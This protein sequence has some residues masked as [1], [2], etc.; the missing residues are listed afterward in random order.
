MQGDVLLHGH[1]HAVV[2]IDTIGVK[3]EVFGVDWGDLNRNTLFFTGTVGIFSRIDRNCHRNV[4][5]DLLDGH[6]TDASTVN[7]SQKCDLVDAF[8]DFVLGEVLVK[9]T[10]QLLDIQ[11]T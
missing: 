9:L 4:L 6:F 8:A 1:T 3:K 7:L 5:F 11:T 10:F 2:H